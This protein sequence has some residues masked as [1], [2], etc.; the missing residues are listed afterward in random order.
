MLQITRCSSLLPEVELGGNAAHTASFSGPAA[1]ATFQNNLREVVGGQ[2]AKW[3]MPVCWVGRTHSVS[4]IESSELQSS[5]D[6]SHASGVPMLD[7]SAPA[8][9]LAASKKQGPPPAG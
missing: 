4:L 3:L 9:S 2:L 6:W 5:A 7:N 8:G 1:C